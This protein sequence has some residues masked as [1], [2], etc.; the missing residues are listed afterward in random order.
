MIRK[1]KLQL[2]ISS[3]I[4]LLPAIAGLI[5]WDILPEHMTT[6][7]GVDGTPDGWSIK[8]F[9]ILGLPIII[10][11]IQ[12]ICVFITAWDPKNQEQSDKV[13][14][15]VLWLLPIVSL[16]TNG[17]IYAIALDSNFGLDIPVRILFGLIFVILGNYMPKCKQNHTIGI[18]VTW[19]LKNEENWTKTHRFTGK[20]WVIGGLLILLTMF[21]PLKHF[22]YGF[23]AIIL[24]LA[25]IPIV[26]SYL[27]YKKQIKEGIAVTTEVTATSWEKKFTTIS[28]VLGLMVLVI[29]GVFIS[30]GDIEIQY[31][32]TYFTL[33]AS[34]WDDAAI[35][36]ADVDEI[37]YREQDER[38]ERTFG[39]GSLRLL[40]GNFKNEEFGAYTRYSYAKCDSCI[41]LSIDDEILV[42][43]GEN[44]ESTQKIY[45]QL[46]EKIGK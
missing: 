22:A 46:S 10:L 7:W 26:Y 35:N 38:G 2:L 33:N 24:L 12:W 45:E 41:V 8:A 25:L 43:S 42:I 18:R 6:H 27:Y 23:L 1:N 16:M 36:Y 21:I 31:N 44:Q 32:D 14:G 40:M 3:I 9:A 19:T 37:E 34:Y 28:L 13:L 20:V 5:M 29:A 39:F 4:I 17:T 11:A 30:T 15:M